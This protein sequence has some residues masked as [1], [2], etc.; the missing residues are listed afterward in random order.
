MAATVA[1]ENGRRR[2][3]RGVFATPLEL[4]SEPQ[5]DAI[6]EQAMT[7]LEEVGIEVV[8]EPACD[9]LRA[10]GQGVDGTR[11]RFDREFVLEQVAKA[12][13]QIELV[14]RNR[15][16]AVRLGGG[17][18]CCTSVGGS[19]FVADR[20]RGRRDGTYDAHVELVKL[21]QTAD[22]LT[23]GQS[24][25][26]EASDLDADSK[27]LDLDYSWL[28]FSDKPFVAYGSSGLRARDS[29]ALAAIACGGRERIEREPA[30][31]GVVNPNSPLVWDFLMVDALWGWAEANQP[32]AMTPFLLAG[33]T[34]PV[35]VAAGLSLLVAEAL[36]G[37]AIAQLVR[38]GVGCLFGSFF[39]A[40]DMRSGGPSLGMPESVLA[41][42]A[43]GQLA[44]RYGLPFRG[45][46]GL[47]S[48]NVLDAQAATESA[49]SLWG[50]YLAGS[51]FVMH[52]AGWLEGGLTASFE[53]LVLDLEVLRM[54]ES[55]R[56]GLDVDAEHLAL[57]AIRDEG[58]GGMFLAAPHTL[59]HFREWVF[60]SPLFRSQAYPTWEKRGAHETPE[61]ATGEWQRLLDAYEDPGIDD[62]VDEELRDYMVRRKAELA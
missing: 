9:L 59:A 8:H 27:H 26:C 25:A 41:T 3:L 48:A 38:P 45:G 34:A 36:S 62:A 15:A 28:R 35:S 24:G 32:V 33:A 54:L 11:V 17:A 60:M 52:A 39:S 21:G 58:P 14:P 47:C 29:V 2:T 51:D 7:I 37:V 4:L 13:S 43:G 56:A 42:I 23:C 12:P 16:R 5:L 53:K 46:G 20:E 44:R 61:V 19:P 1:R 6:H 55:L 57:D 30:I 31:M 22:L 40:V 49:M 10:Q 18:L 50:A